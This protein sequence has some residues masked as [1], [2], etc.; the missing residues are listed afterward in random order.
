[1]LQL[2]KTSMLRKGV[3]HECVVGAYTY[4]KNGQIV[5]DCMDQFASTED[6]I[7]MPVFATNSNMN[8][9]MSNPNKLRMFVTDFGKFSPNGKVKRISD[10]NELLLVSGAA[11][12]KIRWILRNDGGGYLPGEMP[13]E[14]FSIPTDIILTKQ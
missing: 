14:E 1:V 3:S 6:P 10:N 4:K 9:S 2:R 8:P 5:T 12:N 13:P 11:P 7:G